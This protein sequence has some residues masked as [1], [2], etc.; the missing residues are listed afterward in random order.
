MARYKRVS[1]VIG[2]MI[3]DTETQES[4]TEGDSDAWKRY[5]AWVDSGGVPDS[6]DP[7]PLR[8]GETERYEPRVRTTNAAST[9]LM[10][11]PLSVKTGYDITVRVI[12]VDAGN[13]AIAKLV[14]D[15]TLVRLNGAP[16]LV[17]RTDSPPHATG[18]A[19]GTTAGVSGWAFNPVF[20]GN[21]LVM[22]VVG[23]NNRTVDW[24]A[25]VTLTRFSPEGA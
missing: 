9:E 23:A 18:G 12:A 20:A 2:T 22:N 14:I 6:A 13:G 16:T 24:R 10:R 5:Q 21:D 1:N 3:L 17:G 15:A 8:Y 19:A 11:L 4:F 25:V 7:P